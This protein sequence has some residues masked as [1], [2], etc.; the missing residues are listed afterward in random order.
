MILL[1]RKGFDLRIRLAASFMMQFLIASVAAAEIRIVD[2][3]TLDLGEVRIRIDG[4]DAPEF[5]QNC[6]P[7]AC[8]VAALERL[9]T[10]A[11]S[12]EVTCASH[13]QDGYGR[14]IATCYVDG[15]DIGAE[16]VRSGHAWAFV[17]YSEKYSAHE[18]QARSAGVGIW[19]Y[20]SVPAWEYR[21]AK[22]TAAEQSAPQG[23]PIKG[24]IS[25]SGK[26]YHAPWSPWYQKTRVNE[27]KGEHWFC[28]EAE[29][30]AAGWRAPRW[31]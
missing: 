9:S 4:I 30:V 16:M 27:A 7:W 19:L 5:G 24:N 29:A 6:G 3:D 1:F 23:C 18:A 31:Q 22:W 17:K 11:S 8:G 28:S 13:S 2:G 15:T 25:K 10:L 12:G 21:A 14:T 20:D 26:I